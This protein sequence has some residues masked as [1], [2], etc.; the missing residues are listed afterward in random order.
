MSGREGTPWSLLIES[1]ALRSSLWGGIWWRLSLSHN[2]GDQAMC[3]RACRLGPSISHYRWVM[4]H[5]MKLSLSASV[6]ISLKHFCRIKVTLGGLLPREELPVRAAPAFCWT[7]SMLPSALGRNT[8][9]QQ[10][11]LVVHSGSSIL[12]IKGC[13]TTAWASSHP[14]SSRGMIPAN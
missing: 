12:G 10:K 8:Q 1:P 11:L 2:H 9:G 14:G 7:E 5:T 4:K 3:E 6:S 13:E